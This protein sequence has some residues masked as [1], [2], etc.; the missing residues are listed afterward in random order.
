MEINIFLCKIKAKSLQRSE[1]KLN[2]S[3]FSSI[4]HILLRYPQTQDTIA[5]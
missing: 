3:F 1:L 4:L 2:L 5:E